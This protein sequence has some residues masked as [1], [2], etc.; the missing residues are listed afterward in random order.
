[1]NS[2]FFQ[3]TITAVTLLGSLIA[4]AGIAVAELKPNLDIRPGNIELNRPQLQLIRT[5]ISGKITNG[6]SNNGGQPDFACSDISVYVAVALPP[7]PPQGEPGISLPNYQ[8]IGKPVKAQ[9]NITT[10]CEYTLYI[11]SSGMDKPIYLFA[12]SPDKW[13]TSVD[14]VDISP[15]GW[16]NPLQ[17]TLGQ[18]LANKDMRI[19]ATLIK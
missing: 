11:P 4:T 10:G 14:V 12:T 18:K 8:K 19:T 7:S 13:T 9:G 17:I 1:M 6:G 15:V 3:T 16:T 2:K 5:S